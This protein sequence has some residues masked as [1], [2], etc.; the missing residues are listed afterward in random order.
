F[1]FFVRNFYYIF[2]ELGAKAATPGKR[3]LGIRV[4]SRSGGRLT[5]NSVLARNF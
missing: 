1:Y 5:A 4:T 2:F 3:A